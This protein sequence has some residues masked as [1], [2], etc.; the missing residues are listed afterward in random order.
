[1]QYLSLFEFS[2]YVIHFGAVS[3]NNCLKEKKS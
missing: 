2:L 1:M 3:I